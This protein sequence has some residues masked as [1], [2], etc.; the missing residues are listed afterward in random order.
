MHPIWSMNVISGQ[1]LHITPLFHWWEKDRGR[2]WKAKHDTWGGNFKIKQETTFIIISLLCSLVFGVCWCVSDVPW[3]LFNKVTSINVSV[4]LRNV[5]SW[6]T[7]VSCCCCFSLPELS[8][9]ICDCFWLHLI[10]SHFGQPALIKLVNLSV[11]WD[12]GQHAR[13]ILTCS[14]CFVLFI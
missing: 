14:C 10:F 5:S 9:I 2:K 6:N 1:F 13:G 11:K 7:F 4:T 8:S 12:F 3:L